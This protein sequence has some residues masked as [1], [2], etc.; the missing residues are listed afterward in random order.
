MHTLSIDTSTIHAWQALFTIK[1]YMKSN[2]IRTLRKYLAT[3]EANSRHMIGKD[4]RI[5]GIICL[6]EKIKILENNLYKR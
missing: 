4:N 2:N 3:C 6:S 1:H 5:F